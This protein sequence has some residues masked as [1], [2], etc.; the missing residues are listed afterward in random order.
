M[1]HLRLTAAACLLAAVALVLAGCQDTAG[2][3]SARAAINGDGRAYNIWTPAL[4]TECAAEVH[5]AYSTVA[6]D[7]KRYPTWHPPVDP[8][9][10]CSF[11]HEHGRDPR[12]SKLYALIGDLPFGY[13]NERLDE[14]GLGIHRHE[15]HVGHKIEW[16]ND[17][18]VELPAAAGALIQVRCDV[19]TKLHQG[20]HSRD[21]FTNNLHELNYHLRCNEG[22]EMHV[23]LISAIGRPGEFERTCGG[24]VQ[25]G[26][27]TPANS[28][29]G[30]G[31]RKIPHIDC[32]QSRILRPLG[33]GSDFGS[34]HESWETSNDISLPGGRQLASFN[35][36]FQVFRPSRIFDPSQPNN[37]GR[38]LD[39][40]F[41][42]GPN[43]E[44]A[45]GAECRESTQQGTVTG[46]LFDD[47]RSRFNGVR[48][49]VDINDNNIDNA[50]GPRIWYTDAFGN[51]ARTAP[52]PGSVRQIIASVRN[53][54]GF[55]IQGPVIGGNRNYGGTGTR[56]PN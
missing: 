53:N 12:G 37:T 2:P 20:T 56:A 54:W 30:G 21:A 31:V 28:P 7:G 5:N 13:V 10:G 25:V 3:A 46:L 19:M 4:S 45:Q 8:V 11:G 55:D 44:R 16:E 36:Y 27:A 22:T 39:L 33:Q 52:F 42:T 40:C 18:L 14:S 1:R 17:L 23:A 48:R 43:G 24:T 15:D 29:A 35:P 9:S 49:Q 26:P 41:A 32:V 51:N 47:P 6:E 34:L 38:P 50:G